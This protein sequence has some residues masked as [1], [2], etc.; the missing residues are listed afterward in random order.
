MDVDADTQKAVGKVFKE[1][2]RIL[3]E[4][5]VLGLSYKLGSGEGLEANPKSYGGSSR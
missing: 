3:M 5:G 1:F 4:N 2:Q